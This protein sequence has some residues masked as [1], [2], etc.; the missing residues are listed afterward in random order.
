MKT[1]YLLAAGAAA[2]ATTPAFAQEFTGP[3]VEARVS[4]DQ[5]DFTI[6]DLEDDDEETRDTAFDL[7]GVAYGVELGYDA[8]SGN[9]RFGGYVGADLSQAKKCDELFGEDEFCIKANRNLTAGVRG[10]FIVGGSALLYGKGGYSSG[11]VRG[12]Y[13]DFEDILDDESESETFSGFHLG[14]GVEGSLTRNLYLKGEYVYTKYG[15]EGD[16]ETR[17]RAKRSQFTLGLGFRF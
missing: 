3:R 14:G 6:R 1:V 8:G 10:G 16:D 7:D 11:R 9:V 4:Y 13:E 17:S 5:V 2:L 12:T 15:S